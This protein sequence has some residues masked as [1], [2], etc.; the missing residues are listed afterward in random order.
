MAN[1]V[2][3]PREHP[4]AI[5]PDLGIA[6]PAVTF[7]RDDIAFV[8]GSKW[9]QRYFK[10]VGDDYFPLPAQWDV[11]HK[12]WRRYNVAKG[13]DWWTAFYPEDNLQRPTGPLCDGCHSVNYEVRTKKV[14]EWNVGC[15]RCHGPGSE[16]LRRPTPSNIQNPSRMDARH[17]NDVC[18]QCHS[19]G[20]PL[21]NPIEGRYFDW[22]VGFHAGLNLEDFW[23][24]EEHQPGATT[25]THFADGTAH[26]N[27]MQ[28]NDFVTSQMYL[29][30]VTC[31]DCHDVH[32]T[33]HNADVRRPGNKLCLGCHVPNSPIGP[34]GATV[35]QHTHHKE[36]S[37]GS[38]CVACHMPK[39]EQTISDVMVRSH[40]F[41]FIS[42]TMTDRLKIPNS[43]N[44]CHTDKS[45]EW[46][47]GALKSWPGFSPWRVTR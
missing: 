26:K 34:R 18:I 2:R 22:P 36:G 19:Q 24:L 9:K 6:H 5:L 35:E 37:A 28:G 4:E 23:Q 40:T 20:R 41:R 10:R 30:E 29:K 7:S 15:E 42:P 16:H 33:K 32:G 25:F 45:T 46:A 31:F 12:E 17:A 8:Y 14:T 39:I 44:T 3:D 11:T 43:C 13:T 47:L 21:S 1:V 27:R 38:E